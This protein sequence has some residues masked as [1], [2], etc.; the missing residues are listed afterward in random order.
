MFEFG[1]LG[2]DAVTRVG[3][4]QPLEV[5][6]KT[7]AV[8]ELIADKEPLCPGKV[9]SMTSISLSSPSVVILVTGSR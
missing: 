4:A 6:G 1:T 9:K 5:H 3:T 8:R 7:N 2:T